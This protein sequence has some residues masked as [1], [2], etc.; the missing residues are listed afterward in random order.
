MNFGQRNLLRNSFTDS[1]NAAFVHNSLRFL[2]GSCLRALCAKFLKLQ[3]MKMDLISN[4]QDI[5]KSLWFKPQINNKIIKLDPSTL[6]SKHRGQRPS[7]HS[8]FKHVFVCVC[9]CVLS[10]VQ[11]FAA[12]WMPLPSRLLCPWK[13]P[14]NNIG[15]GCHF[16]LHVSS[17]PR[18]QTHVFWISRIA[19][20]IL[21]H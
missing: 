7:L 8:F 13:F 15:V 3:P 12:T 18:D 5:D 1:N 10:R 6:V 11:L 16:L 14:G 9:V 4:N 20:Q 2:F 21:Y 17:Q 19:R